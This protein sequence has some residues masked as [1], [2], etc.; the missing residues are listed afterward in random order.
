M[1]CQF[2]GWKK[3]KK[4]VIK[5]QEIESEAA[6]RCKTRADLQCMETDLRC[7]CLTNTHN[8]TLLI[9][10]EHITMFNVQSC[11]FVQVQPWVIGVSFT[12]L[13]TFVVSQH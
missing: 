8:Y 4:T 12:V 10:S 6:A 1:L 9:F 7:N 13:N 3:K 5:S 11:T 2:W